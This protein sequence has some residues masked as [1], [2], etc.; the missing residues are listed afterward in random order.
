MVTPRRHRRRRSKRSHHA[1]TPSRYR[2]GQDALTTEEMERLLGACENLEESA[3]LSLAVFGGLR[4]E[5]IVGVERGRV[6]RVVHNGKVLAEVKFWEHKKRRDYTI[7]VAEDA[8]KQVLF[9]LAAT[10]DSR[11]LF[12]GHQKGHGH[13]ASKSAYNLLQRVLVRAGL[14]KRPFHALRATCI[15]DCKRKGLSIEDTM[16]LTGDSFRVI[17]EHYLTPSDDEM[18]DAAT[19]RHLPPSYVQGRPPPVTEPAVESP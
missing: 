17:H 2:T 10:Q 7:W 11:W 1:K 18:K 5:D 16:A 19:R 6:Q 14:R 9:Q 12:P 13:L 15:K 8:A 4:R 3:L